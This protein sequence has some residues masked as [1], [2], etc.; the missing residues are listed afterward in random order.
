MTQ[1]HRI[2]WL[3]L[4]AYGH[5]ASSATVAS[6]GETEFTIEARDFDSGNAQVSAI[7]EP[8]ADLHTCIWNGGEL[9]NWV[10]YELNFPLTTEY[11]IWALYAAEQATS[12][13][14]SPGW[15]EAGIRIPRHNRSMDHFL[16]EMGAAVHSQNCGRNAH[17]SIAL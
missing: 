13:R 4:L 3:G 15:R 17:D 7:G 6:G 12:G 14:N 8:F 11:A 2:L 9:P 1:V 10:E 16:G 5:L